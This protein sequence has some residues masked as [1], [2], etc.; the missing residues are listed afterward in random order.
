M[1]KI[2]FDEIKSRIS[3]YEETA[4]SSSEIQAY[5]DAIGRIRWLYMHEFKEVAVTKDEYDKIKASVQSEPMLSPQKIS[6]YY[7]AVAR[8][9][10]ILRDVYYGNA[11]KEIKTPQQKRLPDIE[12]PKSHSD[13]EK[14]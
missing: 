14:E 4:K 6:S 3:R 5:E 11:E 13:Y 8:V 12:K 2:Q 10:D 9:V 7:D 1:F